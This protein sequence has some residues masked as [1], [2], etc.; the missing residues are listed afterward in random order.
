MIF[1]RSQVNQLL[2]IGKKILAEEISLEDKQDL[3]DAYRKEI[4]KD[5]V[6]NTC[7][8]CGYRDYVSA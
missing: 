7:G 1:V 2:R 3:H 4:S 6:L 8:V 5:E